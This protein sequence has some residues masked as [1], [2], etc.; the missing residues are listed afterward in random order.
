MTNTKLVLSLMMMI[1]GIMFAISIYVDIGI[2]EDDIVKTVFFF[3]FMMLAYIFIE[4][5]EICQKLKKVEE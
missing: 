4:I 1:M 3:I 5:H 2:F